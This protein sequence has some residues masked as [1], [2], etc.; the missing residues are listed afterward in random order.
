MKS[1]EKSSWVDFGL[2]SPFFVQ[3]TVQKPK[4]ISLYY[5]GQREAA[6]LHIRKAG[7]GKNV[8]VIKTIAFIVFLWI[9]IVCFLNL[10]KTTLT[11]RNKN[12][13]AVAHYKSNTVALSIVCITLVIKHI[14]ESVSNSS[15]KNWV[16]QTKQHLNTKIKINTL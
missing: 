6:K 14:S 2:H 3:P 10:D 15:K 4:I 7:N 13:I 8:L 11:M 1:K 5:I 12:Y 16:D 9:N